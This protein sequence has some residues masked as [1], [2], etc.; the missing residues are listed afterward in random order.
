VLPLAERRLR[1][2]KMMHEALVE[3]SRMASAT[4]TTN[5][6]LKWVKGMVGKADYTALS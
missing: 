6:L 1:L 4:L 5:D 3:N 2:D